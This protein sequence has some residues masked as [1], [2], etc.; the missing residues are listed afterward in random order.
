MGEVGD[1]R[2][3]VV[4]EDLRADR[5]AEDGVLALAAVAILAHA[6]N[7]GLGLEMLLIAV[8]DERVEPINAFDDDIAA[9]AAIAAVRP[10]ELDEFFAQEADRAGA[11]VAGADIYFGL[12]EKFHRVSLAK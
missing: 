3:V 6:V 8:V 1:Q 10:P 5:D 2:L 12:V 9:T 11:A 7:A 4:L